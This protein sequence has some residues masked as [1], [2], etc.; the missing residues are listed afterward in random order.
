MVNGTTITQQDQ[1]EIEY[2]HIMLDRH[3]L[4]FADGALAETFH[5]GEMGLTAIS[6]AAREE[7]FTLFPTLRSD[8]GSYGDTARICL[9]GYESR[10]LQAA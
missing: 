4:V 7:L 5:P 10:I 6:D 9:K 3:D 2:F 1:D 8:P